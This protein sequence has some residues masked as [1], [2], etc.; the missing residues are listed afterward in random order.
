MLLKFYAALTLLTRLGPARL[1]GSTHL[2][3]SPPFYPLVGAI[4]GVL[5]VLP[6]RLGLAEGLPWVQAWL[7]TGANLWLTRALHWD[8]LADLGDAWGSGAQGEQFWRV[9]KD[10]RT[11]V[12]G[13]LAL[14]FG[15]SGSL[16]LAPAHFAAG[17]LMP[18]LLVPL[19]GRNACVTLASLGHARDPNSLSAPIIA[20]ARPRVALAGMC[21]ALALVALCVN[22]Q[23]LLALTAALA[24][25]ILRLRALALRQGGLNGDFLGASVVLAELGALAATLL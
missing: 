14:F 17:N 9:L 23:A 13:A 22:I 1:D 20:G 3:A 16:V 4:L 21:A 8:G 15:L 18:L 10:S 5:C 25:V 19:V 7:Y 24:F 11:G 12:F 6:F 2:E